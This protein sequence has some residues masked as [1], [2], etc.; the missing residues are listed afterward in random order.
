MAELLKRLTEARGVTGN[1]DEVR[2]IILELAAQAGAEVS[3]DRMGNV[4]ARRPG[5]TGGK[6][7]ML[8]AHMDEVGFIISSIS[9]NGMLKFKPV[10]GIDQRIL[11]SKRVR[12]GKDGIP[13]V[14]G[15]KAIHLQEPSERNTVIKQKQMYIDIGAHSREE[16][17]KVVEAGDYAS[18]DSSF[19]PFGDNKVKAKALDDRAGCTILLELLKETYDFDLIACFTV[20]EEI[21]LRGA[22]VAAWHVEPDMAVVVEGTTCAD[23]PDVPEHMYTTRMGM[24]PAISFMDHSSIADPKLFQQMVETAEN[25]S[26]PYQ[27]KEAI[28]GG[29]DAGSIQKSRGGVRTIVVSVPC[30]Y[31]HSSSSV[32]D[33]ND[34]YNTIAL[35]KEFLKGCETR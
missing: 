27:I 6:K 14:I 19:T 24:G 12:I 29:N 3:V 17:Q 26:I 9:E 21:G 11:L 18:F 33:L 15:V 4:I 16:A 31:I 2:G 10:G 25:H 28:A 1:E 8:A 32:M 13:G 34:Y 22:E 7:I 23:I 5:R 20:Q 35:V 30:R